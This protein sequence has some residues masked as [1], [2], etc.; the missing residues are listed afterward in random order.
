MF[1]KGSTMLTKAGPQNILFS[2]E[3]H[4]PIFAYSRATASP[5]GPTAGA[6]RAG[7]PGWIATALAIDRK[8]GS[9]PG[10][11]CIA[12]AADRNPNWGRNGVATET[13]VISRV[14]PNGPS[15]R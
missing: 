11:V 15:R 4:E 7:R 8:L 6:S 3:K 13:S 12:P 9:G 1:S 2:G 5:P 14:I 10:R